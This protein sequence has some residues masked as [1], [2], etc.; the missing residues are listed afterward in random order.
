MQPLPSYQP[1]SLASAPSI[2]TRAALLS[3]L[4]AVSDLHARVFGPGRFVRTAYRVREGTHTVSR[5]CRIACQGHR[6]IAAI[7]MTEI[8]IAGR[9]GAVMLGP[10][11]VDPAFANQGHG[12]RLIAEAMAAAKA[13]GLGLVLLVGN[14][15]YY[16]R[17]GFVRV[18]PGQIKFPGPVDPARILAHELIQGALASA[19]GMISPDLA[20]SAHAK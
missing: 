16:G 12:R 20:R 2:V 15:S 3:D 6:M 8:L 13:E 10:V 4:S 9:E 1:P 5:F 7:R 11:A 19:Q 18:T 17:L 14:E